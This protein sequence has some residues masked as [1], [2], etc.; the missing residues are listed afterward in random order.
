[1]I[2]S[3]S[4]V[5]TIV[6]ICFTVVFFLAIFALITYSFFVHDQAGARTAAHIYLDRGLC[7]AL[8]SWKVLHNNFLVQMITV[9]LINPVNEK[10]S[11]ISCRLF[12]TWTPANFYCIACAVLLIER[13]GTAPRHSPAFSL[14]ALELWSFCAKVWSVFPAVMH[15]YLAHSS[16]LYTLSSGGATSMYRTN[17]S[18][19]SPSRLSRCIWKSSFTLA[20]YK[21]VFSA[22]VHSK[23]KSMHKVLFGSK[24]QASNII[25]KNGNTFGSKIQHHFLS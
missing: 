5:P 12:K 21:F 18:V 17:A 14:S 24:S 16:Y 9:R 22:P 11:D 1:M 3:K 10:K 25:K 13:N 4:I 19:F 8:F 23:K 7:Q 6:L 2:N 15:C 20:T